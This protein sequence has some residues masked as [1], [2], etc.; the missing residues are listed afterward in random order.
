MAQP[1]LRLGVADHDLNTAI[2]EGTV[3][4]EGFDLDIEHSTNDGL[5]HAGLREGRLDACEYSFGSYMGERARGVP[6]I[7]IPAFPNR[8]FRLSYIFVNSA[9]GIETPKELEGKR[10]GI[11]LWANTAGI[12]A[13]GALQHHYGVDLTAIKWFSR[14]A[15]PVGLPA[16]VTV[17]K[18]PDGS[19]LDEMLV[20]GQLDAVIQA[21]VMPSIK[22]KDPRVRRLF[23]DYKT[24]EQSYFRATGI[25]PIS[26][27]V[28]FPREFVDHH[29]DTP[30]A[31]LKAFR[32][33][34]DQAFD[35]I[36]EQEV[37]SISWASAQLDEQRALMGPNYWAYNVEDN[38]RPLEAMMDFAHEQ[39]VTPERL[40]VDDLFVPEAANL[41]GF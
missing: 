3:K 17:E 36:E 31:V 22:R 24:E 34:R 20:A 21:D 4:V 32:E 39:G 18:L 27:M 12:W 28:T 1:R 35:R 16:G 41:P 8:K 7:A 6:Y 14:V 30:V 2:I 9:T 25:F 40:H 13:R 11:L 23:H 33:S 10:V 15:A 26:H 19:S 29:P 5:I 37:L 38:I